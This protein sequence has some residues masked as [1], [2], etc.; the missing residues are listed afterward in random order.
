M[1]LGWMAKQIESIPA[2]QARK[3]RFNPSPPGVIK[4]GSTTHE[5]LLFLQSQPD[6]FWTI[7]AMQRHIERPAKTISWSLVFLKSQGFLDVMGDMRNARYL[8]YRAKKINPARGQDAGAV[9]NRL[10]EKG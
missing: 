8:K 6:R 4:E 3:A 1:S 2:A 7:A 5:V 9:F 10:N